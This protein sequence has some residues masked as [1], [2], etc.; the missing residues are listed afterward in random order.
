MLA[1]VEVESFP[2][3]NPYYLIE[4][5]FGRFAEEEEYY[6]II[7]KLS[8]AIKN[9][10]PHQFREV[11]MDFREMK[12]NKWANHM[13]RIAI[14]IERKMDRYYGKKRKNTS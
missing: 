12:K 11:G 14:G 4:V 10:D 7:L 1:Y 8:T 2:C 6:E 3:Y 13:D 5:I 9:E